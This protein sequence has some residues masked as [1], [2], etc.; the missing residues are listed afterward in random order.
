MPESCDFDVV[1]YFD[2]WKIDAYYYCVKEEMGHTIYHRFT[3]EDMVEL[4][5]DE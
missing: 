3:R 5:K 2:D 1:F 4:L